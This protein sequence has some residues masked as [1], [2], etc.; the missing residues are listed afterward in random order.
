MARQS[1]N[2]ILTSG[3]ASKESAASESAL[4]KMDMNQPKDKRKLASC[5]PAERNPFTEALIEVGLLP[6][7]CKRYVIDSGLVGNVMTIYFDCF[8]DNRI[9]EQ[10]VIRS[11]SKLRVKRVKTSGGK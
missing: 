2:F 6:V 10:P 4:E 8:L 3:R 7:N 11:L 5:V 9:L 1:L